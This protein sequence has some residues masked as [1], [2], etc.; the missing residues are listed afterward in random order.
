[1]VMLVCSQLQLGAC[2]QQVHAPLGRH[3]EEGNGDLAGATGAKASGI[4]A[5]RRSK[6]AEVA[7]VDIEENN[8]EAQAQAAYSMAN[9]VAD[10]A[11]KTKLNVAKRDLDRQ[12]D[13]QGQME[14]E[15][16]YMCE[17]PETRESQAAE[18][19]EVISGTAKTDGE[20]LVVWVPRVPKDT[21]AVAESDAKGKT[22]IDLLRSVPDDE[23]AVLPFPG[24]VLVHTKLTQ[25]VLN[26]L[27]E[28]YGV[29]GFASSGVTK[30]GS[31]RRQTGEKPRRVPAMQLETMMKMCDVRVVS[32][33]EHAVMA[34]ALKK[35]A[36]AK[37]KA[38]AMGSLPD[39]DDAEIV[40]A[41]DAVD[42]SEPTVSAEAMAMREAAIHGGNKAP[43]GA[44]QIEVKVG[45]FKGFKGYL[46]NDKGDDGADAKLV[47]F[48]RETDVTLEAGEFVT[49]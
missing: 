11:R 30:Y 37:A 32:D 40:D 17:V 2:I 14:S 3:L 18:E 21:F 45:P 26:S 20:D 36:E 29:K 5:R 27:E 23:N 46:T 33:A 13:F 24:Y 44:T 8:D 22:R 48:G 41:A 4:T 38:E 31:T 7:D 12:M 28:I 10:A 16:W 47:I 1:M 15:G 42:A 49:L 34:E 35:Q 39:A 19:I 43:D 6:L 9:P 25:T